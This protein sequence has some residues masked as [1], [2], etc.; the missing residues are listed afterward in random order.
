MFLSA[1]WWILH[2]GWKK[3]AARVQEAVDE[4]VSSVP[5]KG[6]LNYQDAEQLIAKLRRRIEYDADN[7]PISYRS[8]MLPD[9]EEEELEF[10]RGA[11][12]DEEYPTEKTSTISLRQLLDE[13]KDFI[14][15]PDFSQVLSSCLDE[16][17]AIFDHHAFAKTLL[18][19]HEPMGSSIKEISH[20]EALD[21]EQEK[22]VI[23]ANLLPTISRQA[24]LI[25]AGNEYLNA[26]AYI[27]ELQ[28]FSALIYTQYGDETSKA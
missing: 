13:T 8:F 3:I 24:H 26:F 22:K 19:N 25:I 9:T 15:S 27:K 2:R 28:A 1:S 21:L 16:V 11:G 23:L 14:D 17:F 6:F 18:P 20:A 7:K 5:I 4:I 10:I 12:F